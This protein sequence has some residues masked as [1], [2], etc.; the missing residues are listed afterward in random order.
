LSEEPSQFSRLDQITLEAM[1]G[2]QKRGA[3]EGASSHR[4]KRPKS[5]K[6]KKWRVERKGRPAATIEPGNMGILATC[7][8]GKERKAED[9]LQA[10]LEH[11]R[12]L[13]LG[14]QCELTLG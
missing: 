4:D 8:R 11:V 3:E 5:Q 1:T 7:T 14:R 6:A 2:P 9:E 10:L 13:F 12:M